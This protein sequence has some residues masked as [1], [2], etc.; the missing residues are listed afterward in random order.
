MVVRLLVIIFFL[1]CLSALNSFGQ[2][3]IKDFLQSAESDI[4]L[5]ATDE[6][7]G[8]LQDKPYSLSF[9]NR[10]QFR[11]QNNEG[12]SRE[13]Q[14]YGLWLSPTNPLAISS[15]NKY[16]KSYAE[17][18]IFEKE[19]ILKKALADRYFMIIEF[20]Y[21]SEL[22]AL[23]EKD[24][25]LVDA[26][27]DVLEKQLSTDF[28]NPA[29]FT[30]L[31]LRQISKSVE[32]EE[33]LFDVDNQIARIDNKYTDGYI[34]ELN[35]KYEEIISVKQIEKILDSLIT[36]EVPSILLN[37]EENKI[38]MARQSYFIQKSNINTGFIQG[39][40]LP[41]E[42]KKMPWGWVAGITIPLVNPNKGDMAKKELKVIE[43]RNKKL[44]SQ[45]NLQAEKNTIVDKLKKLISRYNSV[46][47]KIDKL[48]INSVTSTLSSMRT[49][50]P[51]IA[52]KLNSEVLKLH[53][54]L[55]KL[56]QNILAGY[57]EFLSTHDQLQQKPLINYLSPNLT[58]L[59]EN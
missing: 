2:L 37:Y 52:L 11:M 16:F 28:F 54:I 42:T 4:A 55:L 14:R 21:F 46:K 45:A 38:E 47:D 10:L 27:I 3:T 25:N 56:K 9:I 29:D 33:A 31:K 22:K 58:R 57:I 39:N 32:V 26:Q 48:D 17:S 34:K 7:S 13:T 23:Y 51:I 43:E 18:L 1:I 30:E 40:Y 41:N 15:T 5:K 24:K 59:D 8:Y 19:M 53:L 35:W 49:N 6:Q 50:N 44:I 36:I 12:I 20:L